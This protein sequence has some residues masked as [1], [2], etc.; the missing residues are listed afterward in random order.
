MANSKEGDIKNINIRNIVIKFTS[1]IF[2][3]FNIEIYFKN[4]IQGNIIHYN[5][6][7]HN[8]IPVF[9]LIN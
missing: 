3:F 8:K 7:Q 2:F 4:T 6:I 1:G 5:T 9:L